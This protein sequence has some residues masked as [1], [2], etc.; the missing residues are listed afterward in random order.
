MNE[1]KKYSSE[2]IFLVTWVH[3]D[4]NG[5]HFYTT[6]IPT[7]EILVDSGE[8]SDYWITKALKDN[9]QHVF[10]ELIPIINWWYQDEIE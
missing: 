10:N 8:Y 1:K 3:Q 7:K 5:P 6:E 2:G 9:L 4:I